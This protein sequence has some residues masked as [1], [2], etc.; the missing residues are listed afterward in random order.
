MSGFFKNVLG[1]VLGMEN[2][3]LDDKVNELGKGPNVFIDTGL[4]GRHK[5]VSYKDGKSL[6]DNNV[7]ERY[8]QPMDIN[9]NVVKRSEPYEFNRR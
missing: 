8:G 4:N 2:E 7:I 1:L 5:P 3:S 6:V 9:G